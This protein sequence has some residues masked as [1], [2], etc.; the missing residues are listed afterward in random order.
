MPRT[1]TDIFNENPHIE[2]IEVVS[3]DDGQPF[4]I[5]SDGRKLKVCDDDLAR[6]L[7]QLPGANTHAGHI[8]NEGYS[9][10]GGSDIINDLSRYFVNR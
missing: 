8:L 9:V 2:V 1:L 6:Q 5:S 3:R 10:R 4:G 7:A